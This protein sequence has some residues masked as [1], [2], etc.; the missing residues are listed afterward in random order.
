MK[1]NII[2]ELSVKYLSY[3]RIGGGTLWIKYLEFM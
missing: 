2:V 3:D 1:E